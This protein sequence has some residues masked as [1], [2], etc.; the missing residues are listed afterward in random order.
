MHE[1]MKVVLRT[2]SQSG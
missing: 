1:P 2:R